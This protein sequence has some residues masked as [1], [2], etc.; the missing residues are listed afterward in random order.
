[1][2]SEVVAGKIRLAYRSWGR[3]W[4]RFWRAAAIAA[5]LVGGSGC[6]RKAP[7]PLECERF[8]H[9]LFGIRDGRQLAVPV[10]RDRVNQITVRCITTPYDRELLD[11]VEGGLASGDV[12]MAAFRVRHPERVARDMPVRVR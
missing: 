12:C 11:C 4:G 7:G 9:R 1:M 10:L 3:F 5:A 8:S 2:V 6:A